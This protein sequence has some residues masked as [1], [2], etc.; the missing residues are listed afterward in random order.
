MGARGADD[1]QFQTRFILVNA[2]P[3]PGP[4]LHRAIP[5][6]IN[7]GTGMEPA[8]NEKVPSPYT[9]SRLAPAGS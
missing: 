5:P 3:I 9:E 6:A 1:Q 4:D 2:V 7:P 8:E